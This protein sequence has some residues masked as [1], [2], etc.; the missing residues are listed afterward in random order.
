MSEL[1]NVEEKLKERQQTLQNHIERLKADISKSHSSDW[2]EAAQERENDE[3]VN[4]LGDDAQVEL[5][6]VNEA[7]QR[8]KAG[9]Y[10]VCVACGTDI[11]EERLQI[12]P[13]VA[14]CVNCAE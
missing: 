10:G 6:E 1:K 3:V 9:S 13:E 5:N 2:S 7:L 4:Q 8:I 12:K 14:Q 11:P